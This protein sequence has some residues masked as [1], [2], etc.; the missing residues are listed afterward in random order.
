MVAIQDTVGL[1]LE[2]GLQS[3]FSPLYLSHASA[4]ATG[5][6]PRRPG[7]AHSLLL[8]DPLDKTLE[9]KILSGE[10]ADFSLLLPTSLTSP[11]IPD[12]QLH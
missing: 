4:T 8:Q 3:H 11:H 9:D 6:A 5:L 12:I 10:Y 1:S 7:V 2:W